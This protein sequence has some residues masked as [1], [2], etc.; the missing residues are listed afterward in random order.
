[1][2]KDNTSIFARSVLMA[3]VIFAHPAFAQDLSPVTDM[4]DTVVE[5]LTGPI[6]RLIGIIAIVGA[7]IMM[8]IGRL[9]WM[10]FVGIFVG[11]VLIFSAAAIVDGFAT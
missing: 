5:A 9:N 6:G 7:G 8:L 2:N 3:V 1:M 10:I 11:I 4:L